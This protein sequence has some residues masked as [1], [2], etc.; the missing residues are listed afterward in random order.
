M[1]PCRDCQANVSE[2][3]LTCPKCGAPYPAREKWDGWGFEY[4]SGMKIAGLP[5]VHVSFK[6]ALGRGPI[7]AK[8]II[9]IGQF[10]IGVV[11]ISQF[12]IGFVSVSQFGIAGFALAQFALAYSLIAQIGLFLG[13]GH[14][15]LIWNVFDLIR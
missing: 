5:V 8:G 11:T 10:A 15:P 3:A 12:G 4:K 14:G 9:A 1:K 6:Y 7:P 13:K 2:Q